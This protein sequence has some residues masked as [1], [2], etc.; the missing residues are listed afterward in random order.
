MS[1]SFTPFVVSLDVHPSWRPQ[2]FSLISK[3][4]LT[5]VSAEYSD[6]AD[7]FSPNLATKLSKHT[8]INTHTIDLENDKQPPY[9]PI[10]SLGPIKLEI[11]KT[12]IETNLANSFIHPSKSLAGTPILF[13]K[14]PNESLCLY[15]DYWGLNN[16]TIKNQYPLSLVD[17]SLNCLGRAKQFT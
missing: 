16:I 9:K 13:D 5:K 15:V 11:F 10:Y 7:I 6:F 4:A 8:K 1:L 12:Y 14:K 17:K 3:K 2:I